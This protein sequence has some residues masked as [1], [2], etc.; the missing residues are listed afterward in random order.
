MTFTGINYIAVII[1]A[2]AGFGLGAV[3][4]TILSRPWLRAIG[5]T[6]DDLK[7]QRGSARAV[8]FAISIVA[9]LIMA[10]MLAGL[11]GHINDVTVRGGVITG[12]FVWLGF[13][14]TTMG[15]NHAFGGAKPM[16]TLIDGLY[17]LAVLVLMGA[18]IGAFG[19]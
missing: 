8:P 16:L 5:K 9:L 10:W 11:L 3:W 17:W 15:V 2:L 1:A 14:I 13:V 6:E 19:V 7:A 12:F 4:Y 18:V